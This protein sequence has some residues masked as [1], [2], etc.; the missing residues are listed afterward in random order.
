MSQLLFSEE[1]FRMEKKEKE[2][3]ILY[4]GI[5]RIYSLRPHHSA[6]RKSVKGNDQRCKEKHFSEDVFSIKMFFI[7]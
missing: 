3:S 2:N 1:Q 5:I 7:K 6:V 4:L